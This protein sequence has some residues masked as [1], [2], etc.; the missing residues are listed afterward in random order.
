[1]KTSS[2]AVGLAES[3]MAAR[4]TVEKSSNVIVLARPSSPVARVA[5]ECRREDL[6]ERLVFLALAAS[7]VTLIAIAIW[8][9]LR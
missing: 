2:P 9:A 4:A 3:M 6:L 7:V 5:A 8:Q 1:M